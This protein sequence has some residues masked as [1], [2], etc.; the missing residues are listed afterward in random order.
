[1]RPNTIIYNAIYSIYQFFLL[2]LLLFSCAKEPRKTSKESIDKNMETP[3]TVYL[4]H[5]DRVTVRYPETVST[6][7]VDDYF[8]IKVPDPYRWLED[9]NNP[10]LETWVAAQS[11]TSSNYLNALPQKEKILTRLTELWDY[12]KYGTPF[13]EG[14]YYYYFYNSGLL[15]QAILYQ[16]NDLEKLDAAKI[17]LDP[18]TLSKDGTTALS[19]LRFSTDGKFMAFSTAAAGSDW[20]RIQVLETGTGRILEDIVDWV[21]YSDIAWYKN[22]F[23]YSRFAET[24][25]A[26]KFT[27]K[28][29]FHQVWYHKLG[30]SQK[31]DALIFA[32]HSHPNY[33]FN[34][35]VTDDERFLIIST[36]ES[37]SGNGLLFKRLD[38]KGSY[39]E[40]LISD[41]LYDFEFV[42]N[43]GEKLIF[44]T[45]YKAP[46]YQLIEIDLK[47]PT[48]K[49][50]NIL[51]PQMPEVLETA[52][53]AGNRLVLQFIKDVRNVLK[54]YEIDG[55]FVGN[56]PL[57]DLV[58]EGTPVTISAL[59]GKKSD[60]IGS[61]SISSFTLPTTACL[62]DIQ[63]LQS[64]IWKQPKLNFNPQDYVTEQVFFK[65]GSLNGDTVSIPLFITHKKGLNRDGQNP[66]ILY[67][68]GGFNISNMPRF[69]LERLPFLEA[70]GIYV[71]ANIRGGGEYGEKWH[72]QG[73][74]LNKQNVFNDF[75]GA[76][77][78]LIANEYTSPHK[79]AIEGRSNGGLLVGACITQRPEL[80]RVALPI[81][82]V[83][84]MLRYHQFTI[85]RA[86]AT[87]YGTSETEAEFKNL[88]AYSPVHNVIEATYPATM[89]MTADHDDRVV[90]AHSYKFSAVL[91]ARQKGNL[92]ILL[93]ID[94]NA[95]HG[96]GK[97]T[98]KL[99]EEIADKL[100]FVMFNLQ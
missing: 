81:V 28:N 80:F 44:K 59:R 34:P 45:N 57:P 54:V 19:G 23:F 7:I 17:L 99:I 31:E 93:R 51:V 6:T 68:Y 30:T 40:P 67:G 5:P 36:A 43:R 71:V 56:L 69:A 26:Q 98:D 13:H 53:I 79:L 52:T 62:F 22:G 42:G 15:N 11:K 38:K 21:R 65:Q 12:E 94:S 63:T 84:D 76:A 75:I 86:W 92:P 3:K 100:A 74:L 83:L 20:Q 14:N 24:L 61:F 58:G 82:G 27:Q 66:T 4:Q 41:F 77:E 91:Q 49:Y 9:N 78:Y 35:I 18:N 60:N 33:L 29:E 39:L 87:D 50:W 1:M 72:Q 32:D 25:D 89:I 70:G 2:T 95:G 55:Q 97:P 85:G 64:D 73:T 47:K 90:P 88:H 37:T 16:C 8:G 46:N 96:V 48:E 10:A